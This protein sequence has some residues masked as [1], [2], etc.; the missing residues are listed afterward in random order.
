[1]K[2]ATSQQTNLLQQENLLKYEKFFQDQILNSSCKTFIWSISE[3]ILDNFA[4]ALPDSV[5]VDVIV[6]TLAVPI[7]L[8]ILTGHSCLI[9]GGITV[10]TV[11]VIFGGKIC[12][13]SFSCCADVSVGKRC[14]VAGIYFVNLIVVDV[15]VSEIIIII[16]TIVRV[17]MVGITGNRKVV[18]RKYISGLS[19]TITMFYR[20]H[21]HQ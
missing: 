1:M 21:N 18:S 13:I 2:S 9:V 8:L 4:V 10:I 20:L 16:V 3:Q 11:F 17:V 7:L 6:I 14:F 19:D 15:G 12:V 5:I